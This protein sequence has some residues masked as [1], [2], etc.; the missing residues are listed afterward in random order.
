MAAMIEQDV[1]PTL[2]KLCRDRVPDPRGPSGDNDGLMK[3]V[4]FHIRR[5]LYS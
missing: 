3:R 5:P 2:D 1:S 4:C